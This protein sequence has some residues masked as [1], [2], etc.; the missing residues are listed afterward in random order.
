MTS[1]V[2]VAIVGG[3]MV[4]AS[5]AVALARACPTLT[6]A[7]LEAVDMPDPGPEL[8]YQPS[9]DARST[10]LSYG[11]RR[12]YEQLGLWAQLSAHVT[13][14]EQI[15]VSDRGH[16]GASRLHAAEH[17]L[18]ALGYVVENQWLGRVLWQALAAHP[19]IQFRC[20]VTVSGI[21]E[22]PTGMTLQITGKNGDQE[23]LAA[24]LVVL[25]DGG[26][27]S[28]RNQLGVGVSSRAYDQMGLVAN[29]TVAQHHRF[30]AYERFTEQ[31]PMALLPLG[32]NDLSEG[33]CALIWTLPTAE[34]QGLL[35]APD[36]LFLHQLQQRFGTRL[37]IFKKVGARQGYPLVLERS[38][39]QVRPG[40]VLVG[41]AA[42]VLHPVAGQGYN[43]ALREVLALAQHVA[44]AA[45][46][47]QWLGSLDVL[48]GFERSQQSDQERTVQFSDHLI[49]IFANDR[50][51]WIAARGL[52]LMALDLI[53]PLRHTFGRYAM[54]LGG[55]ES[56]VG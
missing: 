53:E 4:G 13:P 22:Q 34:A 47:G 50:P 3:G 2:D 7:V 43:L 55:R 25:A 27:S 18:P 48:A 31:G 23:T 52:G 30:V 45:E 51:S 9:Y 1:H 37:G 54:G 26:R 42:H 36:E 33:R 5:L 38:L 11:S 32:E 16:F 56:L 24:Q 39:E 17:R 12:I 28:L 40:L 29:V 46:Q 15:H 8:V 44:A 41:N 10:A 21:Q 19:G 35:N 6:I 20:P 49:R 14:I